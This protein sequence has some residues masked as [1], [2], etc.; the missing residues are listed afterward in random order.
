MT[1]FLNVAGAVAKPSMP[2]SMKKI[3]VWLCMGYA[4]QQNGLY[5]R[6]KNEACCVSR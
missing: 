3:G 1:L 4:L 6:A 5:G 2:Q